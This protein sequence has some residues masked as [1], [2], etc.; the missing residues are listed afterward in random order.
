VG[1]EIADKS[2]VTLDAKPQYIEFHYNK[3]N[4]SYLNLQW[5]EQFNGHYLHKSALASCALILTDGF[6]ALQ[7]M[8]R[9]YRCLLNDNNWW[10]NL[11]QHN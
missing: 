3:P 2:T 5:L 7:L 10:D 11:E 1:N 6:T 9:L 8:E 4:S